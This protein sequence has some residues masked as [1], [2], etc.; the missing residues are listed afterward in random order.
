MNE[1]QIMNIKGIRGYTDADGMAWLNLEDVAYGL[2][3]T[4]TDRKN[5]AEYKR[6]HKQNLQRWLFSFGLI[7]SEKD[8]LPEYIAEP[9]FYLLSMKAENDT[10]QAFQHTIAYDILPA[11]R[12]K[13][14]YSAIPDEQLAKALMA[15]MSDEWKLDNVIIPALRQG[16]ID[17]S[18]LV[19]KY[20]GLT[21]DEYE[22]NPKLLRKSVNNLSAKRTMSR[23]SGRSYTRR[24]F[25]EP[26][27]NAPV[28][29]LAC[30]KMKKRHS[31]WFAEYCGELYFNLQGYKSIIDYLLAQ[32]AI[33]F[34]D[35]L[36]WKCDI[37][38]KE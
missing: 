14:Y 4:K 21:V 36:N 28:V 3:I 26:Y 1:L 27:Q 7:K 38:W 34:E 35:A 12:R 33:S 24:N 2:D 22:G 6:V 9:I 16:D 25:P 17:Q 32:K 23:W 18:K 8:E 13:G 15:G 20:M 10:A 11:I 5:G 30:S 19:A 31:T 37:G 29:L